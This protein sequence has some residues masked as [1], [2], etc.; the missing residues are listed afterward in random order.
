M[1]QVGFFMD[2]QRKPPR[3]LPDAFPPAGLPQQG[4]PGDSSPSGPARPPAP[5]RS[6]RPLLRFAVRSLVI[7][8]LLFAVFALVLFLIP[9][10]MPYL[11][12]RLALEFRRATGLVLE[13]EGA[14]LRLRDNEVVIKHPRVYDP[15]TP[16]LPL[17]LTSV[18]I[19]MSFLQFLSDERPYRIDSIELEGPLTI[20]LASRG[21]R[22]TLGEPYAGLIET[23]GNRFGETSGTQ[24][25][26][27][28]GIGRIGLHPVQLDL[29]LL[30]PNGEHGSIKLQD[31]RLEVGLE[32]GTQPRMIYLSGI[33][34][35][36]PDRPGGEP[37]FQLSLR[38]GAAGAF[39]GSLRLADFDSDRDLP[40]PIPVGFAARGVDLQIE[41]S[42]TSPTL[43]VFHST[44]RLAG[45]TLRDPDTNLPTELSDVQLRADAT[46]D[47]AA[48]SLKVAP[49]RVHS[50]D[51]A[52]T[53]TGSL[54]L[55]WPHA[56]SLNVEPLDLHGNGVLILAD[57]FKQS[58][59]VGGSTAARV[60]L[61]AAVAGDFA[62]RHPRSIL[63]TLALS[64][65]NW[66]QEDF[67]L[68]LLG[69]EASA[70]LTTGGLELN[71]ASALVNSV[72][73]TIKGH[74][75]GDV[76]RRRIA[77]IS[78]DWETRGEIEDMASIA[79]GFAIPQADQLVARGR[80]R[81]SGKLSLSDP[82]EGTLAQALG[83]ARF[84][85]EIRFRDAGL[86]HPAL[87]LPLEALNGALQFDS[88]E[89]R[90]SGLTGK[91]GDMSFG[92]EGKVTGTGRFW[93]DPVFDLEPLLHCTAAE[94]SRIIRISLG[95]DPDDSALLPVLGGSVDAKLH[96]TFSPREWTRMKLTGSVALN[97][98]ATSVSTPYLNGPIVVRRFDFNGTTETL[99]IEHLQGTLGEVAFDL[100]A[101]LSPSQADL[102]LKAEGD[103]AEVKRRIPPALRLFRTNGPAKVEHRTTL[104]AQPGT[105]PPADWGDWI[106]LMMDP[107]RRPVRG[108]DW[109][110]WIQDEWEL[111]NE[112]TLELNNA[113]LTWIN[114]PTVLD[115]ATGIARY[116][117][118]R[119]WT[120]EP[121]TLRA[122]EGS[123]LVKGTLELRYDIP[124]EP[125]QFSFAIS[126]GHFNLGPWLKPWHFPDDFWPAGH[127]RKDWPA[128]T[129]YD[130]AMLPFFT[131]QGQFATQ[132]FECYGV[133]GTDFKS[134]LDISTFRG[135]Q[136]M[137]LTWSAA[138]VNAY[139][140]VIES[141]GRLFN[142]QLE[143]RGESK[144]VNIG[145]LWR[146]L[147]Q[148]VNSG[149]TFSGTLS[150]TML[151]NYRFGVEPREPFTATGDLTIEKSRFVSSKI[152]YSLGGLLKLPGFED[153][154]FSTIRGP[155][156]MQDT[157][158]YADGITFDN[159]LMNIRSTGTIGPASKLDLQ[160][161][162]EFLQIT[163][164]IP[165][166]KN[167][168]EVFNKFAGKLL[169]VKVEGTIS[170][171]KLRL[172]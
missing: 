8:F 36:R 18:S 20:Q 14:T 66:T 85:G 24:Q 129:V 40:Y 119:L 56:Y 116:N 28:I 2:F 27:R 1:F 21:G 134:L 48:R 149:S 84:S 83:R 168:M 26:G 106:E 60:R 109:W 169:Q 157:V 9:F 103:L 25:A 52:T 145:P 132:T 151:G 95:K 51:L 78:L 127:V 62:E 45:L 122:G 152:F 69:L 131:L 139:E 136:P 154:S 37:G 97:D 67:P 17:E 142:R 115:Q 128:D 35:G 138:R 49:F 141:N 153:I 110:N 113:E 172:L 32:G 156:R 5:P 11:N 121:L 111:K 38:P 44:A 107:Q 125:L 71:S 130:S 146:D 164:K 114:M 159:P 75:R 86:A 72:P 34:N 93:R 77:G 170:E 166:V 94:L 120:P 39:S 63:G 74:V 58:E 47:T 16:A 22:V 155:Y 171:P 162:I 118:T 100:G 64:G 140:G 13:S 55:D 135:G 108:L 123:S 91:M 19:E 10:N 96:A 70:S 101:R 15:A 31:A 126:E 81:A 104:R 57:Q 46:V 29:A 90:L 112:G 89:A 42:A 144:G 73:V 160:L 61:T 7:L 54:G 137:M 165:L 6:R 102:T 65:I 3:I 50:R 124:R 68:P 163:E 82:M 88:A 148:T 80:L 4:P 79:R 33:F 30:R 167:V 105:D 23:L 133:R 147:K 87:P 99:T 98:V 12:E 92:L 158:F 43:R 143:V 59:K 161:R 117:D 150:A 53:I 76:L 41:S